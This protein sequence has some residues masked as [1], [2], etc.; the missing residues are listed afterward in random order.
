LYLN[1]REEE[2]IR[3]STSY[4]GQLPDEIRE[5]LGLPEGKSGRFRD[6]HVRTW[7]DTQKAKERQAERDA[8]RDAKSDDDD[9][10]DDDDKIPEV[11]EVE[12]AKE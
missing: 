11:A 7:W 5:R 3:C 1:Q 9:G 12:G 2:S 4:H 6:V 8:E 10:D